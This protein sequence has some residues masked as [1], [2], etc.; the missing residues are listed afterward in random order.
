MSFLQ[1]QVP[2]GLFIPALGVG[3]CMGRAIGIITQCIQRYLAGFVHSAP[4]TDTKNM[5]RAFS[6]WQ[7]FTPCPLGNHEQCI[8]PGV[9]ALLGATAVLSGYTRMTS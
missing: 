6:E 1:L 2:G 8:D 7:V 3:A 9:Y 4:N 5:C